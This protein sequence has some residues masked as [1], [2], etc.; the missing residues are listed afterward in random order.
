MAGQLVDMAWNERTVS[1][2]LPE[3]LDGRRHELSESTR[4]ATEQATN[5]LVKVDASLPAGWESFARILLRAEGIA[6][7][8]VEG[9]T[10]PAAAVFAAVESDDG[11]ND[12]G[13]VADN[14][15]VVSA[16]LA[17]PT[18]PITHDALLGWH[19][20]LMRHSRLPVEMIGS[21]RTSPGWIGGTSP[22]TAAYVAPPPEHVP[23]LMDDL[24]AYANSDR[25]D[26]ITQAAVAHGQFETIHPFG[27]GNGRIGRV[28]IARI[29]ARRCGLLHLPPPTS[30]LIARDAG[31]YISGL[32]QFREG[33]LDA[34][35]RWFATIVN[36]AA[37]ATAETVAELDKIR[38]RWATGTAD[39]R[40]DSAARA[41]LDHL[42]ATPVITAAIAA[43]YLGVS[44]RAARSALAELGVRGIVAPTDVP[45]HRGTGRAPQWWSATEVTE[46]ISAWASGG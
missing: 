45:T 2:W 23:D 14:L 38:S 5:A 1:A 18:A 30:V 36:R 10:A 17:D 28:L 29:L 7:S 12:V 22:T 34:W 24:L 27:D 44:T 25:D 13:W 41:L 43:N 40:V 9:I 4:R 8:S 37:T 21:Y 26:P 20:D 42:I 3:V 16:S 19:R 33:S 15:A 39:L 31:G 35:V 32:W 11:A 46:T 6:S